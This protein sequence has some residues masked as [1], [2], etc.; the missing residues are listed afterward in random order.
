MRLRMPKLKSFLKIL[1]LFSF[2]I[3]FAANAFATDYYVD[4]DG[5]NGNG[6]TSAVDAWKTIT[7][8]LTGDNIPAGTHTLH[9]AAGTYDEDNGE[10][11]PLAIKDNL[12]IQGDDVDTCIVDGPGTDGLGSGN[13]SIFKIS[14]LDD[15][16]IDS[17]T[18][19][20]MG[21]SAWDSG[22]VAL[23]SSGFTI[24]NNIVN[25]EG[26]GYGGIGVQTC[27]DV[28]ISSNKV[29]DFASFCILHLSVV[30]GTYDATVT[31]NTVYNCPSGGIVAHTEATMTAYNNIAFN[32]AT[33]GIY[34]AGTGS[35][36]ITS[37]FNCGDGFANVTQGTGDTSSNPQLVD[38]DN[39]DFRLYDDSI[40]INAGSSDGVSAD[41]ATEI[42]WYQGA[43][44]SSAPSIYS[45]DIYVSGTGTSYANGGTG[46]AGNPFRSLTDGLIYLLGGGTLHV[47]A[48][49]Y[50]TANGESFPLA[51]LDNTTIQ[52][53]GSSA[54]IQGDGSNYV[55]RFVTSGVTIQD[56]KIDGNG[57]NNVIVDVADGS[58]DATLSNLIVY[59]SN[60]Q[61]G[62]VTNDSVGIAVYPGS[63]SSTVQNC[64]VYDV[65]AG[66][67]PVSTSAGTVNIYNCVAYNCTGSTYGTGFAFVTNGAN[68]TVNLYNS[69]ASDCTTGMKEVAESDADVTLTANH[70]CFYNN[71]T[72][73]GIV[74]GVTV[75]AGSN[76]LS[77]TDPFFVDTANADFRLQSQSKGYVN[78]SPCIDVGT[79]TNAPSTDILG[80]ARPKGSGVDMGA[81]ESSRGFLIN[82]TKNANKLKAS[83]GQIITYTLNIQNT[84]G[85]NILNTQVY[86][87][88]PKGFKYLTGTARLNGNTIAEP[89][90][91]RSRT[92]IL[93]TLSSAVGYVLKYKTVVGS[94][95]GYGKSKNIASLKS[96]SS[97]LD[98]SSG[99]EETVLIVPNPIFNAATIIGK[100][101]RD[102]NK[103]GYQDEGEVGLPYI[104][105]ITEDGFLATTDKYGRYHIEGLK[106]QTKI[107]AL[108]T[109]SLP[110]G[111]V[112]TTENPVLLRFSV[113]LTMKANFG[114]YIEEEN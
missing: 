32:C 24:S 80:I 93:G 73:Y 74:D 96:S 92:F 103:N 25:G 107:V 66:I 5:D 61:N 37:S 88:L 85:E 106:P 4:D 34:Y 7:Y 70:N 69:I 44:V 65:D 40:L 48:G 64:I 77:G 78:N 26:T 43:G 46:T 41:S 94:G 108:M 75:T 67:A 100:V 52:G 29:Y 27:N 113:A 22:I 39:A 30:V 101:F 18:I 47:L 6:G 112:L 111:A 76:D 81:Y 86:D 2:L 15:W 8:A 89:E 21:P 104:S 1:A 105:L 95:V 38:P 87:I 109:N 50:N 42:G 12:T 58:S 53:A 99:A 56:L 98:L 28:T 11:F 91:A 82:L 23:T 71:T 35:G 72:N 68:Q 79:S 60:P 3:F 36:G 45:L 114:V 31:E 110:K 17:L 19:T 83:V 14:S 90:G 84:S 49:T 13:G 20:G 51:P 33:L 16:T 62:D 55:F 97:G 9:V 54:I 102:N 10:T 57:Y 63:S 59:D